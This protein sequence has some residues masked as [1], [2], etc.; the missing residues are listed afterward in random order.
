MKEDK[1]IGCSEMTVQGVIF[2]LDF[3]EYVCV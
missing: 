2:N 3:I 1:N